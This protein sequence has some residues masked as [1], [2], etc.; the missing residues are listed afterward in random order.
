ME[1]NGKGGARTV[2]HQKRDIGIGHQVVGLLGCGVR[3]HDDDGRG[4]VRRRREVGVVH[5]RDVRLVIGT[6]RKVKLRYMH[7]HGSL[8]QRAHDGVNLNFELDA[9][10]S[11]WRGSSEMGW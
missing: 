5:E 8:C 6:R 4:R 7:T 3:G 1:W 10:S 9:K 2:M 11:S